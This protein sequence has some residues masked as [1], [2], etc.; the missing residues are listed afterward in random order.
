M[1]VFEKENKNVRSITKSSLYNLLGQG[2]FHI[3]LISFAHDWSEEVQV[4]FYEKGMK[5]YEWVKEQSCQLMF[6]QEDQSI[7]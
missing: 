6:G 4:V 3:K 1:D 7:L 2:S 5:Q